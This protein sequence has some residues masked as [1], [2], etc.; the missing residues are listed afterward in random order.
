MKNTERISLK[1]L[2]NF[3]RERTH[4]INIVHIVNAVDATIPGNKALPINARNED[5]INSN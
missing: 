1:F 5:G 2:S 3:S 4:P